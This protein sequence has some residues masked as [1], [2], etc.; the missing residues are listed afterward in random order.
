MDDNVIVLDDFAME[1]AGVANSLHTTYTSAA[2]L[3]QAAKN[4]I[5]DPM[6]LLDRLLEDVTAAIN[7]GKK[8]KAL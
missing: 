1:L 7:S 2:I 3:D 8:V 5:A 4:A 6:F